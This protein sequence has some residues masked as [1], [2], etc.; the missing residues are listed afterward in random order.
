MPAPGLRQHASTSSY[1]HDAVIRR[2]CGQARPFV[3][4][5]DLQLDT[6]PE[7][8]LLFTYDLIEDPVIDPA[9]LA[10]ELGSPGGFVDWQYTTEIERVEGDPQP[11]T[12][13]Q[14]ILFGN[15][16]EVRLHFR[17]VRVE[18]VQAL[19]P[20]PRNGSPVLPLPASIPQSA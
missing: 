13:A 8:L 15:G 11:P 18:E 3:R 7:S 4:H 5:R 9:A 6:P 20:I 12:W 2:P 10:P 17:D 1:L 19:L 16:W 14:S